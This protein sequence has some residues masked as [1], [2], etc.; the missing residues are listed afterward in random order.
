MYFFVSV[1]VT[2]IWLTFSFSPWCF[3]FR[4]CRR[5]CWRLKV[6]SFL[7]FEKLHKGTCFNK[8]GDSVR[9]LNLLSENLTS[10]GFCIS[11]FDTILFFLFLSIYPSNLSLSLSLHVCHLFGQFVKHCSRFRM[12]SQAIWISAPL[13]FLSIV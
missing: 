1:T 2:V 8:F 6:G 3:R 9:E 11:Y 12:H 4:C 13:F 7:S 5:L 10:S